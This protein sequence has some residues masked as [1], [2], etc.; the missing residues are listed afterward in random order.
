M[1]TL[2][3]SVGFYLFGS[4]VFG[5]TSMTDISIIPLFFIQTINCYNKM[6][7][8]FNTNN[9]NLLFTIL[10]VLVVLN[11]KVYIQKPLQFH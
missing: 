11:P 10:V 6:K 7:Y 4:K 9:H 3:S 2:Y 5:D 1:L 8:L